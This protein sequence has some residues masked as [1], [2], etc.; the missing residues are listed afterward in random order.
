MHPSDR[1]KE[2]ENEKGKGK[3]KPNV[4]PYLDQSLQN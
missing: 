2:K 4:T 1:E 3:E